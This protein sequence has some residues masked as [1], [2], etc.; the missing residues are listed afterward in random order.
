M[1]DHVTWWTPAGWTSG[2]SPDVPQPLA[3]GRFPDDA[4][5]PVFQSVPM[6]PGFFVERLGEQDLAVWIHGEC[7]TLTV[8]FVAKEHFPQFVVQC[9]PTLVQVFGSLQS[10]PPEG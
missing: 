4:Y 7:D 8:F 10:S 5:V 9:L 6:N 2:P 1:T 3:C